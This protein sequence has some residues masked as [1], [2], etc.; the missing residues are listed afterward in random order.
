[1]FSCVLCRMKA[2]PNGSIPVAAK[3]EDLL[4]RTYMI[5]MPT[6]KDVDAT[7]PDDLSAEAILRCYNPVVLRGFQ[8]KQVVGDGNCMYRAVSLGMFGI[9]DFH[10]YLRLLTALEIASNPEYYD[11]H[12]PG[13]RDLI[14][15]NRIVTS[16]YEVVCL[17]CW[18]LLR[19][20]THLCCKCCL[21]DSN[22]VILPTPVQ[23][24]PKAV[25]CLQ[26]AWCE[27]ISVTQVSP[28]GGKL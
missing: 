22:A 8:P 6:L 20:G 7:A 14:K 16:S 23:H 17:I 5:A 15:D 26:W 12:H 24:C 27:E 21:E 25:R 10:R 18:C 1:M 3:N 13:F 9:E 11:S 28:I 19:N 2:R 4:L